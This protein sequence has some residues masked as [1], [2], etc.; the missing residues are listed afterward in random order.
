MTIITGPWFRTTQVEQW[1][2]GSE[3]PGPLASAARVNGPWFSTREQSAAGPHA[4]L[5]KGRHCD[6]D[7]GCQRPGS[8]H[9]GAEAR[10]T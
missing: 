9:D 5:T 4:C 3:A 8:R 6:S 2:N 10:E 7:N 1:Q